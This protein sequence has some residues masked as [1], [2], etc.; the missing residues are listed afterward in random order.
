MLLKLPFFLITNAVHVFERKFENAVYEKT[1]K[2]SHNSTQ[3][4]EW[5]SG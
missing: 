2:I 4:E 3:R 1:F 5:L